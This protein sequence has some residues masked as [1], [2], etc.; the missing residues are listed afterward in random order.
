MIK[1][2]KKIAKTIK[3]LWAELNQI[4]RCDALV[5][6]DILVN[7]V[8]TNF[9]DVYTRSYNCLQVYVKVILGTIRS[10]QEDAKKKDDLCIALKQQISKDT[11]L[12]QR[13]EYFTFAADLERYKDNVMRDGE[14]LFSFCQQVE[15]AITKDL[16][17][18]I[19]ILQKRKEWREKLLRD[20]KV[21]SC[22]GTLNDTTAKNCCACGRYLFL[23]CSQQRGDCFR[24]DRLDFFFF[25]A[26]LLDPFVCSI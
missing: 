22:C 24:L 3:H 26:R 7:G 9:E 23:V 2:N 5:V 14:E 10:Y 17:E 12:K 19:E 11:I 25:F 1:K 20:K 6:N 15:D 8:N 16:S 18:Y 4:S 13:Y 21:C